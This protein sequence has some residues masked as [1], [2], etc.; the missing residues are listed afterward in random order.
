[1]EGPLKQSINL[2]G[3]LAVHIS[4]RPLMA[5]VTARAAAVSRFLAL[6]AEGSALTVLATVSNLEDAVETFFSDLT[7]W[8]C[9]SESLVYQKSFDSSA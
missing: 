7:I 8:W 2:P 6:G 5:S 4:T 1:M 3:A 9:V